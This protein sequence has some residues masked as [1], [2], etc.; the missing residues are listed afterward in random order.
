MNRVVAVEN[1][2][3]PVK[4]F[5]AAKGCE[6]VDVQSIQNQPVDVIVLSGADENVM[7]IQNHLSGAPVINARGLTPEQV[8]DSIQNRYH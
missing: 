5:L 6:V 3:G 4:S 8:W 2:L 7:N 1:N